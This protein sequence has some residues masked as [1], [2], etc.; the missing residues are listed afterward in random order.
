MMNELKMEKETEKIRFEA[1][2][3]ELQTGIYSNKLRNEAK[4]TMTEEDYRIY[5][6]C[7]EHGIQIMKDCEEL[8][9]DAMINIQKMVK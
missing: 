1:V 2:A 7:E 3:N 6:F 9:G 8:F 4:K 5:D